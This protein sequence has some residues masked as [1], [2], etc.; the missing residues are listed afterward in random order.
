VTSPGPPA[1]GSGYVDLLERGI[2][3]A[4]LIPVVLVLVLVLVR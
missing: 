2:V 1:A 3:D 4:E